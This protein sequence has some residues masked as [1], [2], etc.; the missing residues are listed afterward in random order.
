VPPGEPPR[1]RVRRV[2]DRQARQRHE[3]RTHPR[4][5]GLL[6]RSEEAADEAGRDRPYG[7]TQTTPFIPTEKWMSHWNE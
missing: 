5:G 4:L 6:E 3:R 2:A 7:V 1:V